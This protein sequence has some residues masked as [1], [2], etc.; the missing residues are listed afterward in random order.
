[1]VYTLVDLLYLVFTPVLAVNQMYPPICYQQLQWSLEPFLL[2][3]MILLMVA[4]GH[5][6]LIYRLIHKSIWIGIYIAFNMKA[7]LFCVRKKR[8]HL[9]ILI[10]FPAIRG[11]Q[12]IL[13]VF[14]NLNGM[15]VYL[16]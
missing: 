7:L 12:G 13:R 14:L 15:I 4:I 16:Q 3:C 1:M 11:M 6:A 8:L 9:L 10:L 5:L 2:L